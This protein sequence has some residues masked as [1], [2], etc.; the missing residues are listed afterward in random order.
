MYGG[1]VISCSTRERAYVSLEPA[2]G[3]I[4]EADEGPVTI[5]QR[6]DLQLKGDHVDILR[7]VLAHQH[8]YR[9][10]APA[11]LERDPVRRRALRVDGDARRG[12]AG[13]AGAPGGG[14]GAAPLRRAGPQRRAELPGRDLR[15]PGPVHGPLRGP[16]LHGLPG[17]GV[18]PG[19][20]ERAV[21]HGGAPR[22][23]RRR[24]AGDPG[25]HRGAAPL[26]G[27]AQAD[28]GALAG[29]RPGGGGRLRAHRQA[30]PGGQEGPA[31]R[32]T[33]SCWAS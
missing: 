11:L 9:S 19:G 32:G 20:D 28:P 25:Q 22:R 31:R 10:G 27:G 14:G 33:G 4:L 18:L 6:A 1:S 5:R 7:A 30:G 2:D 16:E 21:R 17:Q 8:E 23:A 29:G 15:L 13:G 26:G 3:L 12:A 24:A